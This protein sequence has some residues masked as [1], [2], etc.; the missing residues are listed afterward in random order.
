MASL[1]LF[2]LNT[3]LFP[4]GHLPLQVFEVRYLDMVKKCIA[5]DEQFGV[6]PLLQGSEVRKPDAPEV[7]SD[8]GTLARIVEWTAP[9][10]GLL[11]IKCTGTQRFRIR[12]SERLKH[13]LWV[14]G[15]EPLAPDRAVAIPP[16]QQDVANALGAL[17][18]SL[19]ERKIPPDQMPLMPPFRLDESG[20]VANRWCELLSLD[21]D[22]KQRL[23]AQENPVLRLELI[24][25]LLS[26]NGLLG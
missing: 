15:V 1:P 20:W 25:D 3:V 8:V 13:G 12:S 6:V 21:P 16:E 26:E 19:Q 22:L 23:L 10:P 11:H 9:L 17:I 18:R 14:A 2:P 5:N 4:D 24:Q 7:L